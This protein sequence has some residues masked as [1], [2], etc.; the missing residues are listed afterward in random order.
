MSHDVTFEEPTQYGTTSHIDERLA[1]PN[2]AERPY[3][4][5]WSDM[6]PGKRIL[7]A[8]S[9][10]A[11]GDEINWEETLG[12]QFAKA[13]EQLEGLLYALWGGRPRYDTEPKQQW[14]A[15]THPRCLWGPESWEESPKPNPYSGGLVDCD[16]SDYAEATPTG[17]PPAPG[18]GKEYAAIGN[19]APSCVGQ[20]PLPQ[21]PILPRSCDSGMALIGGE[22]NTTYFPPGSYG[23][24]EGSGGGGD[25]RADGEFGSEPD[26]FEVNGE[27]IR[28]HWSKPSGVATPSQVELVH[29]SEVT[30]MTGGP[31]YSATIGPYSQGTE[32]NWYIRIRVGGTWYYEPGGS[33]PPSHEQRHKVTWFTHYNPYGRGLPEMLNSCRKGTDRYYFDG[34]ETIQP[35]LLNMVR[36]TLSFIVGQTCGDQDLCGDIWEAQTIVHHNP[37]TRPSP[38]SN[39]GYCC[40]NMPIRWRW[41]G[42]APWPQYIH[43]GKGEW[44]E[45]GAGMD[46]ID[47]IEINPPPSPNPPGGA[48]RPTPISVTQPKPPAWD[49][50][51]PLHNHPDEPAHGSQRARKSWRGIDML[52]RSGAPPP[53]SWVPNDPEA[54]PRNPFYGGGNSW[55]VMPSLF[56][57]WYEPAVANSGRIFNRYAEVGLR[58]GDVIAPTH[59]LEI[60]N[61]VEYL[62]TN[63]IWTQ[64]TIK[65]RKRTPDTFMGLGCG[66]YHSYGANTIEQV[67]TWT[68][69][70]SH[71]CCEGYYQGFYMKVAENGEVVYEEWWP[72]LICDSWSR[73]SW[74]ECWEL[75][76]GPAAGQC[77]MVAY[78]YSAC[79]GFVSGTS[80]DEWT[81]HHNVFCN[82]GSTT[83]CGMSSRSRLCVG[84]N[85]ETYECDAPLLHVYAE[86]R[87]E[88]V[89]GWSKFI[90]TPARCVGG[91][92]SNHGGP[93]RKARFDHEWLEGP[94]QVST[95]T[96]GKEASGNCLGDMYGCGELFPAVGELGMWFHEVMGVYWEGLA[97][98]WWDVVGTCR[99]CHNCCWSLAE[100]ITWPP[101]VEVFGYDNPNPN[102]SKPSLCETTR[103]GGLNFYYGPT[104]SNLGGMGSQACADGYVCECSVWMQPVCQGDRVWAATDLNLDGSGR[105]YRYFEGHENEFAGDLWLS[106]PYPDERPGIPTLRSYSLS[107]QG[108]QDY[109]SDCPCESWTNPLP[110]WSPDEQNMGACCVGA[111]C[112]LVDGEGECDL[113]G[114]VWQGGTCSP[115]NPCE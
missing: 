57:C 71:M 101:P 50:V 63:G 55:E 56:R 7:P 38:T 104:H 6:H 36:F 114:G 35:E 48:F 12:G 41:S 27:E 11:G 92:D 18:G 115:Y 110:C 96:P 64:S 83:G 25:P 5:K 68:I 94:F 88:Q 78:R 107:P 45:T 42:S 59:I 23:R 54:G 33:S 69:D 62:I 66:H 10:P 70:A 89:E 2:V 44:G 43:G 67:E 4:M 87:M 49:D 24:E 51:R 91:P 112:F 30:P 76:G 79:E 113:M 95:G 65:S 28:F 77:G 85:L 39:H 106:T 99:V 97:Q 53:R 29:D 31:E 19:V 20:H 32:V 84:R 82:V 72:T 14:H 52:F 9:P 111:S 13:M 74:S 61:A 105:A 15:R 37:R 1:H 93:F 22:H 47:E 109:G 98:S 100:V 75:H 3:A 46:P 73:P 80:F 34:S 40:M 60:I 86:V 81:V 16:Y 8:G 58:P 21:V 17:Y 108:W 90:C 26:I 103:L 102:A